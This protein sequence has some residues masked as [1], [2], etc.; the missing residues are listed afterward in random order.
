[1]EMLQE[2]LSD[3]NATGAIALGAIVYAVPAAMVGLVTVVAV[4]IVR[5]IRR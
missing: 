2:G 3:P 1:M 5:A 4:N